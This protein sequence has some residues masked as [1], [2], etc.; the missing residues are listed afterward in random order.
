[1]SAATQVARNAKP[2]RPRRRRLAVAIGIALVTFGVPTG[3]W[4]GSN[5][6]YE[7]E[8]AEA[9]AET[10]RLDP[11]WRFQ[12]ILAD[13]K[14]IADE[15]NPAVVLAKV[16]AL[17][18]QGR[19][20]GETK[21]HRLE[22]LP[23]VNQLSSHQTAVLRE[24]LTKHAEAVETARTLM[25]FQCDAR[26]ALTIYM[27][28]A[29]V[30]VGPV[31]Q[32][33]GVMALL[34]HDATLRAEER[35][36]AGALQSCQ[37]LL[38][39]ARAAGDEPYLIAAL[40][41]CNGEGFLVNALERTLAQGEPPGDTLKEMQDGLAAAND[42]TFFHRVIRGERGLDDATFTAVS[43]GKVKASWVLGQ[44]GNGNWLEDR[45]L[46][47]FPSTILRDRPE[48]LRLMNQAVEAARLPPEKQAPAFD[49]INKAALASS[50]PMVRK[51]MAQVQKISQAHR[52]TNAN[53]RCA[54]VG[55]AA[56][57]YGIEHG[58]WPVSLDQ[59]AKDG[60]IAAVPLDPFDGQPLRYKLVADGV[61]IYSVGL[62]GVD[63]GGAINRDNPYAPGADEGFRLWNPE[64]RRQAPLPPQPDE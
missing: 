50:R 2:R 27:D 3:F 28:S 38:V 34:L 36:L 42:S 58:Q 22:D 40:V 32:C 59:L 31:Q 53:L 6:V 15:E 24:A 57:R 4:L 9:L 41:R 7:R 18:T 33:R 55:I 51:I 19:F 25:D 39:A 30:F 60:W 1:M 16:D 45:I 43:Q 61:L 10:E 8:L 37:A 52:R 46:D 23:S 11:R 47:A 21:L 63:N 62:D 5:W 12:D 29:T 14:P 49:Q 54:M 13:R 56:E 26:F 17:L 44:G 35:D 20:S 48:L 64:F